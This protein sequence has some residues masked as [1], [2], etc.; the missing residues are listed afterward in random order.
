MG[1]AQVDTNAYGVSASFRIHNS[2]VS[3]VWGWT[4]VESVPVEAKAILPSTSSVRIQLG[5]GVSMI[6]FVNTVPISAT[7]SVNRFCLIRNFAGAQTLPLLPSLT[8][9]P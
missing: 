8:G 1:C 5:A 4:K 2:V 7:R 6:T 9:P 3:P